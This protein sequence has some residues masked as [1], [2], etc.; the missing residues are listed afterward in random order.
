MFFIYY[1]TF[2]FIFIFLLVNKHTKWW[3]KVILSV[4]EI[5]LFSLFLNIV[6]NNDR[7]PKDEIFMY[8]ANLGEY[9]KQ[10]DGIDIYTFFPL[11]PFFIISFL[12]LYF[13]Y[14]KKKANKQS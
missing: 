9:V 4:I 12:Y 11:I 13:E 6:N 5:I 3:I 2:L 1:I 7:K 8:D 14:R 10:P